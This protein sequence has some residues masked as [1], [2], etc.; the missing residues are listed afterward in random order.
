MFSFR[1]ILD[2]KFKVVCETKT[3]DGLEIRSCF[4][5]GRFIITI[6]NVKPKFYV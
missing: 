6:L 1:K 3:E 5:R 2:V 4:F